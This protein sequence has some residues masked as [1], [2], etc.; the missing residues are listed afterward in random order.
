[1]SLREAHLRFK[2]GPKER[3]AWLTDMFQAV[4]EMHIEEP[5]RGALRWFFAQSSAF[6]V[7]QPPGA[8]RE[9]SALERPMQDHNEPETSGVHQ[10]IAQR[11]QTQQTLEEIVAAVRQGNAEYAL[12]MLEHPT[13]Q[14]YFIRDRAAFLNMLAI[15]SSSNQH[16]L[17]NSVRQTLVH[18][19]EVEICDD[20]RGLPEEA[21]EKG[22]GLGFASMRERATER[23]QVSYTLHE[24]QQDIIG[25]L[26]RRELNSLL[27][28]MNCCP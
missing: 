22:M 18:N 24:D 1:L 11:W 8:V 21:Q 28:P 4:D 12:T 7:N 25:H 2:I 9:S 15:L 23:S 26:F 16:V 10:E 17:L 19:P 3:E 20:G 14:A 6:L 5:M 13:L 27:V